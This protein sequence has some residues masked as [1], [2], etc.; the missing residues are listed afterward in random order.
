VLQVTA[1]IAEC[2]GILGRL[3]DEV[4]IDA[5]DEVVVCLPRR[6]LFEQRALDLGFAHVSNQQ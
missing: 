3:I 1:T 2:G 6:R 5:A 4:S